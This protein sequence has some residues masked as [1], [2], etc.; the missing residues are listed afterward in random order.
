MVLYAQPNFSAAP[1]LMPEEELSAAITSAGE[2]ISGLPGPCLRL[3]RFSLPPLSSRARSIA[4]VFFDARSAVGVAWLAAPV[5]SA[6]G[7]PF[8]ITFMFLNLNQGAD[9]HCRYSL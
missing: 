4:A 7:L 5:W 3:R 9:F 6:F 1:S 8:C 2:K